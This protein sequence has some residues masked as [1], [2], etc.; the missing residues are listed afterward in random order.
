M[1][2]KSPQNDELCHTGAAAQF[3]EHTHT[4]TYTGVIFLLK[5]PNACL[6]T[7]LY[8]EAQISPPGTLLCSTVFHSPWCN[9]KRRGNLCHA[10]SAL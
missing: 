10:T 9:L 2:L 7:Q 4:Y 5:D 6:H 1:G 8:Q 3:L